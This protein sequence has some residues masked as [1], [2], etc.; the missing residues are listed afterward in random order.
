MKEKE[1]LLRANGH[2]P[3]L[4]WSLKNT[5]YELSQEQLDA[6]QCLIEHEEV[7]PQ[8]NIFMFNATAETSI[9]IRPNRKWDFF[10]ANNPNPT[11]ITQ[12]RGRYRNDIDT[13]YVE[14]KRA[15]ESIPDSYL[16]RPVD[17]TELKELRAHLGMK[18]DKD[19]HEIRIDDMLREFS[20]HGYN[21]EYSKRNRRDS[22]IIRRE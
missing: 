1:K 7:P 22:F 12:S 6:R 14:D 19:W 15:F 8:Y 20:N 5:D 16:D 17:R 11:V 2:N 4:L 9:N 21:V 13:L 3:L 18:K 10:I